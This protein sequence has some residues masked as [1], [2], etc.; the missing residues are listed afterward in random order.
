[1]QAEK[2]Q[3]IDSNISLFPINTKNDKSSLDLVVFQPHEVSGVWILVE[4]LIQKACDRAGAFADAKDVKR[5]LEKGT[6][7]LWVA[8]D[9]KDKKIKCVCVTELRQYPKYKVCDCKIT[10]GSSFKKWVDFMDFVMEWAKE[11]GCRKMEIHTRP[12]WERVLK[13]KGFFKTH[14]QLERML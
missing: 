13:S 4:D 12:G 7:Q 6:M 9:N 2:L 10:T 14:V 5:W 3:H 11:E 8:F 1:M